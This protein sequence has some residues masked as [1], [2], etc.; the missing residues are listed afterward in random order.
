[1]GEPL[2][3]MLQLSSHAHLP[4]SD[5]LLNVMPA[6]IVNVVCM[7][8]EPPAMVALPSA[9]ALIHLLAAG[10][11]TQAPPPMGYPALTT[12]AFGGG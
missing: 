4:D 6:L 3:C 8:Y 1:M 11:F 5:T 7:L 2:S 12:L 10:L 9:R